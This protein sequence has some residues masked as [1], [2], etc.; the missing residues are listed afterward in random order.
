MRNWRLFLVSVLLVG[1]VAVFV[2]AGIWLLWIRGW[3]WWLWWMLPLCW[4]TAYLIARRW[5]HDW[6]NLPLTEL[7]ASPHWTPHDEQALRIIEVQQQAVKTLQPERLSEPRFYLDTAM[8]LGR[9]IARHY[10][11]QSQDPV[12]SLTIPEILAV[13]HLACEDME[14]WVRDYVP[15]SH[16]L[17]VSQWRTLSRCPTGWRVASNVSWAVAIVLNPANLARYLASRFTM[18]SASSQ[19]QANILAWF[20]VAYVRHVGFYLIEMNSG[21]LRGGAERYR[22]LMERFRKESGLLAVDSEPAPG[23]P[24]PPAAGEEPLEVK[25]AVVGQV[26]AGKSSLINGLLGEQ[27]AATD[28]LPLTQDVRRY[29]LQLR[30]ARDRAV[31]LDTPG[32]GSQGPD[33]AQQRDARVALQDADLVLL[34]MNVTNPARQADLEVLRELV[35]WYSAQIR[36]RPPPL[37]GVLTHIDLLSPVLEWSPDF[38]WQAATT[39]KEKNIRAAVEHHQRLFG[40]HLAGVIP[41]CADITRGRSAGIQEFLLP[42][43]VASLGEARACSLLRTLHEELDRGRVRK[44][45]QQLLQGGARLVRVPL[46]T[47]TG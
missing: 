23:T 44:L 35:G 47:I 27:R 10:H 38:N 15:G 11:P 26:K 12:S 25:I 22:A 33:D 36:R 29:T 6:M 3:W 4:G 1:P 39:P 17:T 42:A 31:L 24:L 37:L 41:V 8:E 30:E 20:Y 13:T 18:D 14:R 16:L 5:R 7:S 9:T 28:I 34:V 43:I 32:Y 40:E 46:E 19:L 2:A 45:V 21:R